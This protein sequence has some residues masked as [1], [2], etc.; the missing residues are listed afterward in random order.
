MKACGRKRIIGIVGVALIA[1]VVLW[2]RSSS[3]EIT[4]YE[5]MELLCSHT[6][7]VEY[8]VAAPYFEDVDSGSDYFAFIQSAVEWAYI[9]PASSFNGG[10]AADGKFVALSAMRSLGEVKL[11]VY[12]QTDREVTDE[13]YLKLALEH[14][15]IGT[16]D[17]EKALTVK[18]AE[19]VIQKLDD[20]YYR[21]FWA[22]GVE[23][24]AYQ[25]GVTELAD[26]DVVSYDSATGT[27]LVS[28][29]MPHEFSAGDIVVF[30]DKGFRSA[31][32]IRAA[33][34]GNTYALDTPALEDVIDTLIGSDVKELSFQDIAAYYGE[35]NLLATGSGFS[36][37]FTAAANTFSGKTE[38]KGFAIEAKTSSENQLEIYVTDNGT[39][40]KYR[41]PVYRKLSGDYDNL[42]VE[43]DVDRIFVGSQVK[44]TALSGVEYADVAVDI[45]SDFS[46]ELSAN[47]GEKILLFETP[48][49]LGN[50]AIGVDVKI[51]LVA[52]LDGSISLQAEIPS[53]NAVHYERGKGIRTMRRD[54][55]VTEPRIEADGELTLK[56]RTAPALVICR[57][58]PVLDAAFD[59][60]LGA[61]ATVT[62]RETSQICTDIATA[63]PLVEVTVGSGDELGSGQKTLLSRLGVSG[64]W[65]LVSFDNAPKKA[66]LHFEVLP[67]G[68]NQFVKKCTYKESSQDAGGDAAVTLNNTYRT[69]LA[70]VDMVTAPEY[71]FRYPESWSVRSEKLHAGDYSELV[72]LE[73]SRGATI[74]YMDFATIYGHRGSGRNMLRVEAS[75]V[76]D[77]DF[78]PDYPSGT[79][80]DYSHLGNFIVA[81]LKVT[82][83][84][85][86]DVD[87]DFSAVDG[88][89][90]YAVFPESYA[91]THYPVGLGG[92]YNEFA[93]RYPALYAFIAE[94]PDGAFTASER[95]DVIAILAS[96][97]PLGYEDYLLYYELD[98]KDEGMPL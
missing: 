64:R 78:V 32:K 88:A 9:E 77:S 50:G 98:D 79:G 67:D 53:Q 6:G 43:L 18:Q 83:T 54:I 45:H 60:G 84:M 58:A 11:Q 96:F 38:H 39:G 21:V 72:I 51:Y 7:A 8:E 82:G 37:K 89:I 26:A 93:F 44:Y 30:D 36:E 57:I 94:S 4:R 19:K 66:E 29:D 24:I 20:L 3:A 15:L 42:S 47:A 52:S 56:V 62:L 81:E 95:S 25:E 23:E 97:R 90:S 91:G 31:G 71:L 59:A 1:A 13:E 80:S 63:F 41:L 34:G 68:T 61:K 35:E 14:D 76:A 28:A 17:L 5:W 33:L 75:K 16:G 69:R 86:M 55:S 10:N 12:L 49:P 85:N 27:L 22:I 2:S 87:S 92:F 40:S 46:G 73:N 65:E 48:V 70:E 74:T